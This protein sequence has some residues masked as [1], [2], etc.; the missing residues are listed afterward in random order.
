MNLVQMNAQIWFDL[1]QPRRKL[2]PIFR[3]SLLAKTILCQDGT[4]C[5]DFLMLFFPHYQPIYPPRSSE[6]LFLSLRTSCY[7]SNIPVPSL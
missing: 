1:N 5:S 7:Q 3:N 4:V 2:D 6:S